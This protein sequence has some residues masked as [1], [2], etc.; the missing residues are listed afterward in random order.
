MRAD[1]IEDVGREP[2]RNPHFV[3]FVVSFDRH[4]HERLL[5][6]FVCRWKVPKIRVR[7][8]FRE[9]TGIGGALD[10][11]WGLTPI[12]KTG[13]DPIPNAYA[14]VVAAD[15]G[16]KRAASRQFIAWST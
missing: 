9:D 3:L 6:P 2:A 1:H 5:Q 10:E 16:I 4:S 13:S 12:P 8:H 11:K 14:F 7:P 15:Y